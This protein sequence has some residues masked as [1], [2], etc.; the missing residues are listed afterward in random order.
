[1]IILLSLASAITLVFVIVTAISDEITNLDGKVGIIDHRDIWYSLGIIKGSV[2]AFGD[3]GCHQETARSFHIGSSQMPI[4]IRETMILVGVIIGSVVVLLN[5]KLVSNP[6]KK[7]PVSILLGCM[8][9]FE[10]I[11]QQYFG[12]DSMFLVGL[13]GM[14][15]GIG[16]ATLLYSLVKLEIQYLSAT[17]R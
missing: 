9:L 6:K 7:I 2:Y 12:L 13:S 15:S 14:L 10:W 4:C 11:A 8:A 16:G 5:Q 3:W 1:M 17:A